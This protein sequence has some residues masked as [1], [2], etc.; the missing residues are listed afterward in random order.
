MPRLPA[1]VA[2]LL[3]LSPAA[4]AQP[5]QC[6]DQG[7]IKARIAEAKA[8]ME[9]Y[10]AEIQKMSEQM[11]RTQS[12]LP[13]TRERREKLQG[14][15]QGAINKVAAGRIQTA[16]TM[17]DNP[18]GT[19]NLC[20]VTI[21]LH[22]SATACMRESVRRHEE[23]HRQECLKT[24]TAGKIATSVRTGADRF[25]RDGF[26]LTQYAS[27]EMMGYSTEISFLEGELYRLKTAC[28][29]KREV[30]DYTAELRNRSQKGQKPA[31]PVKGGLD[32][33]RKLLGF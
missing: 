25:E 1:L 14:R 29:P 3:A 10:G 17:G 28:Q 19:D 26:Q 31:D 5:C 21:G 16:P 20:N 15:V 4:F 6:I 33:A 11:M 8:A 7:D 24:R 32:T 13:Y 30:R 22:P 18:G 9:A 27:E 2:F 23:H 12:P